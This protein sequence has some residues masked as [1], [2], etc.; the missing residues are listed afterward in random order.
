MV[1]AFPR[2]K[3]DALSCVYNNW[4]YMDSIGLRVGDFIE[5]QMW[6]QYVTFESL[7]VYCFT[8]ASSLLV[9]SF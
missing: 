1:P 9:S 2:F 6:A 3:E 4:R 8:E 5:T 7:L